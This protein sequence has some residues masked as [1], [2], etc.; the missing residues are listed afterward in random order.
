M[1]ALNNAECDMISTH[2]LDSSRLIRLGCM[3]DNEISERFLIP[4]I[5]WELV[6]HDRGLQQWIK[7][8]L[9]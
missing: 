1:E 8:F 6:H 3:C 4:H 2:K 5:E 9:L 7:F